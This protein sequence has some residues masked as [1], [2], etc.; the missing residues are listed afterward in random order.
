[1]AKQLR[2]KRAAA[3]VILCVVLLAAALTLGG[4]WVYY[5]AYPYNLRQDVERN[6]ALYGLD[7]LLVAAVIR[8]ESSWRAG[9]QSSVGA[10]GLMQLMPD[11][12]EW[13]AAKNGWEYDEANLTDGAA[14]IRLGCWYLGYLRD[15]FGGNLTLTL[16]AY[17]AGD[18]TVEKWASEGRFDGAEP[19]IPFPETRSFVK[20]VM[21]SYETYKFLY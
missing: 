3:A 14:N 20:K 18:N 16:A 10:T 8:T 6:A 4:L 12:G 9:A 11:T 13:I 5:R 1:M 7:P 19:D 17:N 21:D 2:R 15:K